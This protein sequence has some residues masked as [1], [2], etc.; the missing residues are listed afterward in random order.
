M[1]RKVWVEKANLWMLLSVQIRHKKNVL[2]AAD[3]EFCTIIEFFVMTMKLKG[4]FK[5]CFLC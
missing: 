2:A 1:F 5:S 3:K 4:V